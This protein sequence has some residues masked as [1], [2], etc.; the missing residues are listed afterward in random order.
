MQNDCLTVFSCVPEQASYD[1]HTGRTASC[2]F[3]CSLHQ[4]A[5]M[6]RLAH[7]HT[8]QLLHLLLL[9]NVTVLQQN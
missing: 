6:H 7:T 9:G 1:V 8:K 4:P 3:A 5:V 2:K